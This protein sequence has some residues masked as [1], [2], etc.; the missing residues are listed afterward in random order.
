MAY[1]RSTGLNTV[2]YPAGHVLQTAFSQ[3]TDTLD[4]NGASSTG[5]FD[6]PSLSASLTP[7]STSNKILVMVQ[8][9]V[10][11]NHYTQGIMLKVLR[12]V[13]SAGYGEVSYRGN[14]Q[15][16]RARVIGGFEEIGGAD[17]DFLYNLFPITAQFL[18]SAATALVTTYK[19]QINV[20]A[21][22]G[23][24]FVNR[25]GSDANSTNIPR[26]A[27]SITLMEISQ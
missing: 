6:V 3:K 27:S 22:G 17:N 4:V 9:N 7:A 21:T 15:D 23:Y 5:W 26:G 1:L 10:G 8:L 16:S 14:T 13:N 11:A 18:D 24:G 25:T 2:S 19:V 20:S 12:D